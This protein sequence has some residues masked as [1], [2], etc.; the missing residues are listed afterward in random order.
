MIRHIQTNQSF[1]DEHENEIRTE[2]MRNVAS[3]LVTVWSL[4]GILYLLWG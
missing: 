1:R 3:I 4:Y 2:V